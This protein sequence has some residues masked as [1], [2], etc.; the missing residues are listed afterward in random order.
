[1]IGTVCCRVSFES[2]LCGTRHADDP[3]A[4]NATTRPRDTPLP[5]PVLRKASAAPARIHRE[6]GRSARIPG[7]QDAQST[8][9]LSGFGGIV[10]P[11]GERLLASSRLPLQVP[12]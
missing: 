8:T 10:S 2:T 9:D 4:S 7:G 5:F 6:A 12:E 11:V 3:A 1:M